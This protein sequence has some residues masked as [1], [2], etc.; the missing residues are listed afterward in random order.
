M[1][2]LTEK[3][4]LNKNNIS[5]TAYV[6]IESNSKIEEHTHLL[7]GLLKTTTLGYDGKGQYEINTLDDIDNEIDWNYAELIYDVKELFKNPEVY[8][9]KTYGSSTHN[10]SDTVTLKLF[11]NMNDVFTF[12]NIGNL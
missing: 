6:P 4:F 3:N 10:V 8:N 12:S 7:P 9:I 11:G 1:K 5:T 2:L